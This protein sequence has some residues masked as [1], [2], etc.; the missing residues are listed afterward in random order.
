MGL[1]YAT[2]VRGGSHHDTRPK[3]FDPQPAPDPEY[4]ISGS[5]RSQHFT[6]V[7]DSLVMC[8]F[9]MERGFGTELNEPLRDVIN[10]AAGFHYSLDDLNSIGERIYNMERLMSVRLGQNRSD[11]ALPM[12][13]AEEIPDGP[14]KGMRVDREKLDFM[15]TGYYKKRG[16]GP[17]GIP[18]AGKIKELG[19]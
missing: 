1:G 16:W 6:A 14:S 2:S 15:L 12:R 8:R 13:A 5:I 19:L 4:I 3:Y 17:D 9:V 10:A 18:G 11:D 7:G